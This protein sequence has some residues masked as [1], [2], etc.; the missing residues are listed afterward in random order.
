MTITE[1]LKFFLKE[2]D[3]KSWIKVL[4]NFI[5]HFSIVIS[6]ILFLST[7]FL[8]LNEKTDSRIF[9]VF[10]SNLEKYFFKFFDS[11]SLTEIYIVI[12]IFF[13]LIKNI[14]MIAHNIYYNTFIFSLS[15]KKSAKILQSYINKSYED[16]SKKEISIY[17]K[18]LV[19][20]VENVFVG[21][22]WFS[23]YIY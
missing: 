16:F 21:I 7:F 14:L 23:C 5:F 6:E 4:I 10:F 13:L 2:I 9:N 15:V 11:L 22:F 20:D 12:L 17:I 19:R 8:I 1:L 3:F 18:Q